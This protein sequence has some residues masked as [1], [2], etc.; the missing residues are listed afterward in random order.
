MSKLYLLSFQFQALSTSPSEIITTLS[1]Q[2]TQFT[3]NCFNGNMTTTCPEDYIATFEQDLDSSDTSMCPEHFK[4]IHDD[5][6]PW[7]ST[8][9]T[10]DMVD[11]GKNISHFRVVIIK[12]KVY[13]K[14]YENSFQTRDV[15][16]I[17]GILQLLRLYPGKIP[18]LELLFETGDKPVVEK[19]NFQGPKAMSPPPIFHYCGQK[20]AFDIVFPDWSFWGW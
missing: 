7:K 13:I 18:D 20:D 10:R 2:Q 4:W 1:R 14:K 8:G 12:G 3:L 9:I 6:K 5:L 17:W 15:F 19:Q 11:R 16:T